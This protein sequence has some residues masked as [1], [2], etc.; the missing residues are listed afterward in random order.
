MK[1]NKSK[2]F[3][4]KFGIPLNLHYLCPKFTTMAKRCII[5]ISL[6]CITTLSLFSQ[7]VGVS[8]NG[9]E[10][11]IFYHTVEQGQTVYGISIMYNVSEEDIYR[12]NPS[13]REFIKIGET[14]KIPQ[15]ETLNVSNK[16]IDNVYVFHTIQPKE[17]L[18]GVSRTYNLT[19][20]DLTKANPGISPQTFA[21]GKNI[22]IPVA[23]TQLPITEKRTVTKEIDYTVKRRET[24]FSLCKTFNITSDQLLQLNPEL[25]KGLKAGMVIKIPV[26]TDEI[27]TIA[28]DQNEYDINV[29]MAN[30]N[31]YQKVDVIKIALLLPFI[32]SDKR[33][34]ETRIEFYEGFL[35]AVQNMRNSGIPIELWLYDIGDGIQKTKEVLQNEQLISMNLL[36]GGNTNEQ[37]IELIADFALKNGS[38][39]VVPFSARSDQLTSSNASIFQVNTPYQYLYPY[40]TAMGCSLFSNYNIVFVASSDNDTRE[41]K[42]QFVRTFKADLAQRNISFR[43]ITYNQGTFTTDI[44]AFLSSTKPNLIVPMS[45]SLEILNKIKGPLRV[46]TESK[47]TNYITLFGYPEWQRYTDECLEDFYMLNTHIYSSFFANSMSPDIQQFNAKYTYWFNKNMIQAYPKYAMLG[48]DIGMFFISAIHSFGANFENNIRQVNYDSLQYG[49]NFERVNNWGG[50]INT[51]LY[52][53]RYQKD[54]TITRSGK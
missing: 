16:V 46:L 5:T 4:N 38:K 50:F 49:F 24:I 15:K 1:I 36:I 2:T 8:L 28:P 10:G 26:E 31:S 30:R 32:T 21:V 23:L 18:F 37:T 29:L 42:A 17:T 34:S 52:M 54:F 48:Y 39:Y 14:L 19:V 27:V 11:N 22:R 25:S 51:N 9:Q 43:D 3:F 45:S 7:N 12:L 53:V 47:P 13:S 33:I 41:D 40:A 44:N 6:F 35:L 20:E